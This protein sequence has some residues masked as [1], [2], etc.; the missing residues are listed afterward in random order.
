MTGVAEAGI[1]VVVLTHDR[2]HLLR[3]CVERVIAGLSDDTA[4]I[5]I[6]NNGSTDGTREFLDSLDDPR[7][8]IV[9][10]P[11]NVG[12]NGYAR[13]VALTSS[14]YIVELDDD[15]VDA[16]PGWDRRL[17]LAFEQL[18]RIGYLAADLEDDPHDVASHWRYRIRP[19]EYEPA[20]VNGVSLLFGPTGGACAITSRE[21]Y[22]RAGGFRER[23]G[24]IFWTEDAA[25]IG[26]IRRL[27]FEAAVLADLKV[28]HTGGE[29]YGVRNAEKDAFWAAH[30]RRKARRAAVKRVLVRVPFVRRLNARHGW[31]VEPS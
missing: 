2:V 8:R 22:E 31:F 14:P 11:T 27:G 17:R 6:W 26:D 15:V 30:W 24:K 25:Y 19:H 12:Q 21:L 20:D 23:P 5:V 9:H 16:P 3:Q 28:H 18:P 13:S 1:A 7:L 29:Y 4:E 10:N